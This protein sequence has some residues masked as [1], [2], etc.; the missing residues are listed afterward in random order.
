MRNQTVA[1]VYR[2]SFSPSSTISARIRRRWRRSEARHGIGACGRSDIP[3]HHVTKSASR[4][5][6]LASGEQD[7]DLRRSPAALQPPADGDVVT[8]AIPVAGHE[9]AVTSAWSVDRLLATPKP[10]QSQAI[11]LVK[12]QGLSIEEASKATGQS[13]ALVKVNIPRGLNRLT[14]L[15]RSESDAD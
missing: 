2:G 15:L 3:A 10:A 6:S 13:A 1:G 11:R 8:G 4:P 5:N 14:S 7:P 9:D 12:L